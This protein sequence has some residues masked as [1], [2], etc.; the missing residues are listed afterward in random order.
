MTYTKKGFTL[1]EIL[2]VIA[3]TGLFFMATSYLTHDA[4]IGQTNTE[5][6]A[7]KIY[8]IIRNTRNDMT[9]GR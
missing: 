9:I 5:R 4:R 2:I 1:F 3:L 8:D 7:N 6:F